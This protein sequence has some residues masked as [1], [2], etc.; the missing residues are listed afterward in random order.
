ME[1][2]IRQE[3]DLARESRSHVMRYAQPLEYGDAGAHRWMVTIRKDGAAVDLG[4]MSAKCY[5]TRAAGDAERAQGVTSVTVILDAQIDAQSG[6]V[7]C[8]FDAACYGGVG[9]ASAILRLSDA[10]GGTMTAACLTARLR[11]STSDAVYD[12]EGL[13]PSMD[14]LLAQ[15]ATI[16]AATRAAN[17]AAA[18][19]NAAAQ[20]A[21]FVVLG[22]YDTLALLQAAHPAGSAGDAW[23]IGEAEP[24]DVYVWDVDR[25][26]WANIG[27]LQG[28]KGEKG[29]GIAQIVRTA[30]DGSAGSVD[31]YSITYTDGTSA[32]Y[33]VT[34]GANGK[35]GKQGP[36]GEQGVGI[37]SIARTAGD[38]SA[39]SVDTYTITYTDGTSTTYQ[40]T[41][42]RN[43]TN[44]QDGAPGKDAPTYN[45]S[46]NTT[47]TVTFA[48]VTADVV[49]GAVFME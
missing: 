31:T 33:Q 49:Y 20:S 42:G 40:V 21:N 7:S 38:G 45:Q 22:Q 12:P 30:G 48:S 11:R 27:P 8:V 28:A 44:G 3:V 4:A 36:K 13:V 14:A 10:A 35:D 16:E 32:T 9:A 15:I 1:F 18:A 46:L 34:N 6:T 23:A 41:N 37:A 47:D 26:A 19:A 17:E 39:G 5:V 2:I 43:G 29:V 24:Y 25:A